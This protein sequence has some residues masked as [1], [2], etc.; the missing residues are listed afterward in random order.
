MGVDHGRAAAGTM[1]AKLSRVTVSPA[2]ARRLRAAVVAAVAA[3]G[4]GCD[5]A[6]ATPGTPAS[7]ATGDAPAVA[8]RTALLCPVDDDDARF[9]YDDTDV[10]QAVDSPGGGF[11]VHYTI[12]DGSRSAVDATDGD[13]DG[14]PD[15]VTRIA[16]AFDEA[17]TFYLDQGYRAP[18][19]D[20][21]A[22]CSGGD[23][24]FDVYIVDLGGL[25]N[26]LFQPA[27]D[28]GPRPEPCR[29]FILMA[30]EPSTDA[31]PSVEVAVRTLAS[32]E[33]FHAVQA[34]YD[35]TEDAVVR[36]GTAVWASERFDPSLTD[37]ESFVG[38]YLAEPERPLDD[39]S[40]PVLAFPYGSALFFRFLE[41]AIDPAVVRELWEAAE[42]DDSWLDVLPDVLAARG[43]DFADVFGTF[44]DWNLRTGDRA[45]PTRAYRDGAEYPELRLPP[46]DDG[47][48]AELAVD[49]PHAATRY[50]VMA[51]GERDGITAELLVPAGR[52]T[53][54]ASLRPFLAP[55]DAAGTIG[56]PVP[57]ARGDGGDGDVRR[58]TI[59]PAGA[60]SVLLAIPNGRERPPSL[61]PALC[62]GTAAEVDE[63]LGRV[64]PTRQ[65]PADAGPPAAADAGPTP[66]SG[67]GGGCRVG[68]TPSSAPAQGVALLLALAA[69]VPGGRRRRARSPDQP[70]SAPS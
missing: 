36:E 55:I 24:R 19:A 65:D 39:P 17:L 10:V 3:A 8:R 33:L 12:T 9:R 27:D 62:M 41:E 40:P 58:A 21:D 44:A 57:L 16:D 31:F 63:C 53:S 26:A 68:G 29:G 32:H 47:P 7:L 35:G 11:R 13:G 49:I 38:G 42:G 66:G 56:D 67:G 6:S 61:Q 34:A 70:G 45:D 5:D 43:R 28:C 25:A 46:A 14:I 22:P 50:F 64:D 52:G 30:P 69:L 37:L 1:V 2:A 51:V 15:R 20:A 59:D 4:V 23:G 60:A 54:V 48:L 18:L